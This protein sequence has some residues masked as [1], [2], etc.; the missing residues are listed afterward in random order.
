MRMTVANHG[1]IVINIQVRLVVGPI[2]PYALGARDVYRL[3]I[4]ESIGR[5]EES[6]A[7]CEELSGSGM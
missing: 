1:D 4:E 2:H 7:P 3:L 5:C 6:S